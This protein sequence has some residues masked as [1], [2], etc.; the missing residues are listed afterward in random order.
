M[1]SSV[2]PKDGIWF[3]HL[4]HRVSNAVCHGICGINARTALM[5][6]SGYKYSNMVM[7][8]VAS[9]MLTYSWL[10]LIDMPLFTMCEV[11]CMQTSDIQKDQVPV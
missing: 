8:S 6:S 9:L 4:C 3:L 7:D 2:S 5:Y 10:N 1:D 11:V